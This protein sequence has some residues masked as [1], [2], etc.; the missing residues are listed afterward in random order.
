[1][2]SSL[3]RIEIPDDLTKLT[4]AEIDALVLQTMQEQQIQEWYKQLQA[5]TND[6]FMPYY[7][8]EHRYLVLMG[9]A[10][11]GKSIF[12]GRKILERCS[13]EKGHRFLVCRKTANTLRNSCFRQLVEQINTYYPGTVRS[14]NQS[15]MRITFT[16]GNEILFTGLDDVEKLKS[17]YHITGIWIEEASEIL[18]TDFQQLDIR[19]RDETD[20]YKQIILSFNPISAVHWLKKR[21]FDKK[22]ERAVTL[23]TTYKDNKFLGEDAI[24][25]LEAFKDS[26]PYYYS[27]YCLGEWGVTGQTVFPAEKVVVR[28]SE[29]ETESAEEKDISFAY[30]RLAVTDAKFRNA[31]EGMVTVYAMPEDGVPYVIGVDTAGEGSDYCVAQVLDNTSGRQVAV[32]RIQHIDEDVFAH[33]LAALGYIYNTALIGVECNFSTFVIRE[34]ERIKYPKQYV[35]ETMD[36]YT[37]RLKKSFGFVT[38]GSNRSVIVADLVAI[39]RDSIGLIHDRATL[40]EMLTFVRNEAGRPE[41]ELGAHDD[42]I[43]SL[44]IAYHIRTQQTA[45]R[46]VS[47]KRKKVVW[48]KDMW[49]DY[50]KANPEEREHLIQV[51]G[52][53]KRRR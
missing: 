14:I 27:V 6:A 17:I 50:D 35:R 20:Y 38:N 47:D 32:M 16:N 51:W 1:M 28:L 36:T 40:E 8:D 19:M 11:S 53:P 2:S 48:S 33:R 21:F 24:K 44:A 4:E 49:E 9:G 10:G 42:C 25:T 12:A 26:D 39:V 43:M 29:I 5:T 52:A 7:T 30:D 41:A 31:V 13:S 18:E 34:L 37:H 45:H 46:T 22:D 15:D 3:G 23:K